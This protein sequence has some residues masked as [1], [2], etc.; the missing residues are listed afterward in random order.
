[1]PYEKCVEFKGKIYCLN[2]ETKKINKIA[3][4]D[5]EIEKCPPEV[6]SSLMS[7][8]SETAKRN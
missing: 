6:L 4:E 2:P 8:L 3:V 5:V 7:I 1:M